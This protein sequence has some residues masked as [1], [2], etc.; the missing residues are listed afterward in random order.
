MTGLLP[1]VERITVAWLRASAA[2]GALIGDRIGTELYAGAGAAVWLSVVTGEERVRRHLFAQQ[3]DVRSYGGSKADAETLAA[4]VHDE[5]HQMIGAQALGTVTD[6]R[7]LTTPS[8][9][10]DEVFAPPRARYIATYEI[11]LHPLVT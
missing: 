7:C 2:V 9:N 3:I 10:P 8:W 5:L 11:V 6:V 1:S 4:T